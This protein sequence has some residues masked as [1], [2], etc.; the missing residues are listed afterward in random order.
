MGAEE[1]GITRSNFCHLL[2]TYSNLK[3]LTPLIRLLCQGGRK[4]QLRA[5]R[6]RKVG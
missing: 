1:A 4:T 2:L 5:Q 6:S 3:Q